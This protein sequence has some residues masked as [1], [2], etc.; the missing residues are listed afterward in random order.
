M[1]VQMPGIWADTWGFWVFK[2]HTALSYNPIWVTYTTNCGHGDILALTTNKNHIWVLGQTAVQICVDIHGP[3]CHQEPLGW[4]ESRL[5]H[6]PILVSEGSAADL[7]SLRCHP[8]HSVIWPGAAGLGNV[9]G[10]A[11]A[12]VYVDVPRSCYHQSQEGYGC[13]GLAPRWLQN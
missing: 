4:P 12:L 5:P 9:H 11:T 10:S 2:G 3:C 8:H 6:R 13:T 1:A 7:Y